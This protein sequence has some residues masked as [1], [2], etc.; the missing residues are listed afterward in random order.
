MG[1]VASLGAA[2]APT[3]GA[4][5]EPSSNELF[6]GSESTHEGDGYHVD[7]GLALEIG[8]LA[9]AGTSADGGNRS[10]SGSHADGPASSETLPGSESENPDIAG[11]LTSSGDEGDLSENAPSGDTNHVEADADVTG[12]SSSDVAE[13]GLPDGDGASGVPSDTHSAPNGLS[14]LEG[15]LSVPENAAPTSSGAPGWS[16]LSYN[17]TNGNPYTGWVVDDHAGNGLQRYYIQDGTAVT[18][19]FEEILAGVKSWFYA[20][21]DGSVVRGKWDN[22]AGRVYLADNDGRLA[23]LGADGCGSGWLVTDEYDGGLQRYFIDGGAHAAVSGYFNVDASGRLQPEGGAGESYFGLGGEGYVLRG[24]GRGVRGDRLYADNDG[25]LARNEWVVTDDFGQGLQRYW[26]DG[27]ASMAKE[28]LYDTGGGWWTYVTGEGYVLRGKLDTGRGRVYVAD[29]DGRLAALG[30]DGTASGW[31]VTGAYDGGG[32]QR[33]YIDGTSHAAVSGFFKIDDSAYF[34]MGG[35]GYVLCGRTGWGSSVLLA[36]NDGV[37]P[38]AAGWVVSDDHGQGLQRYWIEG[39]AGQVG[40]F[41][42]KTGFFSVGGGNY[43]GRSEGYVLRGGLV[44]DGRF[45][46]ANNDGVILDCAKAIDAIVSFM[47]KIA[48]DDSHGYTQGANRWG[49]FGDYDCSALVI[50]VLRQAGLDTGAADNTRNM[51]QEFTKLGFEWITNPASL[52]KGDILLWENNHTVVYIGDGLIAHAI[53]N[54][55]GGIL[56]GV[57]G[58]QTGREVRIQSYDSYQNRWTG[59]LRLRK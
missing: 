23:S 58:D 16:G 56:G 36:N 6:A 34:G 39:I 26:F 30:A 13:G 11:G 2:P 7:P 12:G 46:Y 10:D 41:G 28:G 31:L 49:Q 14:S 57:P 27:T 54:E 18:G 32:L 29:N 40:Y 51:R 50:T 1:I 15:E 3:Y 8:S 45:V 9:G 22:R 52:E 44:V 43:Y 55:F 4:A 35:Q 59:I 21:E 53:E 47:I 42:A 5:I 37:M 20:H 24:A 17:D 25:R 19:F 48:D 33:Y 38:G